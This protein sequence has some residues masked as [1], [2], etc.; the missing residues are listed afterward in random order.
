MQL[1]IHILG[2]VLGTSDMYYLKGSSQ[3][4]CEEGAII[5]PI[6]Q[7]RKRSPERPSNLPKVT[8]WQVAQPELQ[9]GGSAYASNR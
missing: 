3:H 7:G 1:R 6:S 2:T 9:C 8:G 4:P 5:I